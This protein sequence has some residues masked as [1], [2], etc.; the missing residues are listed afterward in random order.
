MCVYGHYAPVYYILFRK[1]QNHV[2]GN[3]KHQIQV[4]DFLNEMISRK[5]LCNY[6]IILGMNPT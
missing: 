3:N 6:V 1:V 2:S 5:K 4:G